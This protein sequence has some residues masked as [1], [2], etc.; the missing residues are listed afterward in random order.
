MLKGNLGKK[1]SARNFL[2]HCIKYKA[3]VIQ[4]I[5]EIA[6]Y[7]LATPPD[8]KI[9]LGHCVRVALGNG[10]RPDIWIDFKRRFGIPVVA[11]RTHVVRNVV[12][13]RTSSNFYRNSMEAQM[14]LV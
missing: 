5:G 8:P 13:K 2:P 7:L 3:T 1:F 6:R 11:V 4:Y 14:V 9:D 12:M 10:M